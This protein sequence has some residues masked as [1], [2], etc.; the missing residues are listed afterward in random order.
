MTTKVKKKNVKV[1]DRYCQGSGVIAIRKGSKY[2]RG[3]LKYTCGVCGRYVGK[4]ANGRLNKHGYSL[5]KT[6]AQDGKIFA[7]CAECQN[8]VYEMDYLCGE[9]RG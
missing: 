3:Y 6:K 5:A 2:I 9:C 4:D 7:Y 8:P 1:D